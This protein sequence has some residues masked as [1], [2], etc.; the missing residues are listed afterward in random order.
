MSL[1]GKAGDIVGTVVGEIVNILEDASGPITVV[2]GACIAVRY[3]KRVAIRHAIDSS[4]DDVVSENL[5][6]CLDY[7][8]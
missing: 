7:I 6:N 5:F 4:D 2:T 3:V 1:A 8:D